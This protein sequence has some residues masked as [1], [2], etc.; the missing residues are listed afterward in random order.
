MEGEK[1]MEVVKVGVFVELTKGVGRLV[2][3]REGEG[4]MEGVSEAT[5]VLVMVGVIEIVLVFELLPAG[6]EVI[7]ID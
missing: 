3:E 4:V 1:E 5:A 2:R 6:E 7:E